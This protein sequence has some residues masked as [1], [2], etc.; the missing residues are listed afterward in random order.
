M[1]ILTPE[2]SMT[3]AEGQYHADM[4]AQA[5]Y[6]ASMQAEAEYHEYNDAMTN[7]ISNATVKD[8]LAVNDVI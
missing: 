5:G 8:N 2:N 1:S 7:A 6:E 3:D 4:Q